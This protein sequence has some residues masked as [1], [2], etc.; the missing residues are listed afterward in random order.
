MR[1]SALAFAVGSVVAIGGCYRARDVERPSE[2]SIVPKTEPVKGSRVADF[3]ADAVYTGDNGTVVGTRWVSTT[4]GM[5]VTVLRI[6]SV[7]QVFLA[8]DTP[9]VS[10]RGEPHTGEHLL[11]GKGTKGKMLSLEQDMSLVD[12]TAWTAQT[13]VCYSWSCAAGKDT[14]Y[15]SVEQ[16]LD[17]LLCPDFSD[18]EIRR[19]VCHIGPVTDEK[20][21][22][23]SVDEKGTIYQEMVSTY[24]KR[25]IVWNEMAKRLWGAGHPLSWSSGGEPAAVRTME[26]RHV[27]EFHAA[28]YQLGPGTRMIVALP[29]SVPEDEFLAK[30]SAQIAA[31]EARPEL[32]A[33]PAAEHPIP[34]GRPAAD[35]SPVV[36]PY[37]NANEDDVGTA[38]IAWAPVPIGAQYDRVAAQILLSTLADGESATLYKRL[39]DSETREVEVGAAE[40]SS[41]LD[42]S[43]IDLLPYVTFDGVPSRN[44]TK[45]RMTQIADVVSSEVRRVAG[46]A[47]DS[48]ALRAFNEKALVKLIEFEKSL[49]RQLDSPP[50]FGHR[51]AGGFWLDQLR[52]VD[53]DPAW[54]RPV[55]LAPSVARLRDEIARGENPWTRIVADFGLGRPPYVGVSAP[56]RAELEKRTADHAK[57]IE[58]YVADLTKRYGGTQE[59]AL[60]KFAADYSAKTAEVDAI[61]KRLGKPKLVADVPLVPDPSIRLEPAD[62]AGVKGF[63]GIFDN[64]TFAEVSVSFRLD[65]VPEDLYPWLAVLPQL[66]TASGVVEDGKP[67]AYDEAEERRAREIH[68]LTAR[69]SM[70]P[71][72]GR[73]ELRVTAS[74]ADASETR[75][76][77]DWIDLSIHHARLDETNLPRLRD[78][79]S[80]A[81]RETRGLLGGAEESWVHDPAEAIRWQRDRLYLCTSSAH[82]RLFQLARCEWKLMDAPSPDEMKEVRAGLDAVASAA[83]DDAAAT[84][85]N[86]DAIVA[87]LKKRDD[88]VAKTWLLPVTLRCREMVGD[89]APTTIAEDLKTLADVAAAD[90]AT[91]PSTALAEV[92]RACDAIFVK[93]GAR[94]VVTGSRKTADSLVPRLASLLG[95][96]A[97]AAPAAAWKTGDPVV[98][99]RAAARSEAGPAPIHYGLVNNA[100]TSGVFLMSAKAGGL[101]D[102]DEKTLVAELASRVFGGGGSHSLFMKTW[103]AGLAYSNGLGVNP[104]E[105]RVHYYAERCPDLVRTMTFATDVVRGAS[106]LDDPYLAEYCVANAVS[107]NRASDEYEQRARAAA[108][109]IADGDTPERIARYRRAVLALKDR[110]GLWASMKPWI[111]PTSGRVLP[112]AGPATHNVAGGLFVTIAPEPLLAR[113]EKYLEDHDDARDR[114]VRVYGR[115]FWIVPR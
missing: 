46:L 81:I 79:V 87:A 22:E 16:Y 57:R 31:I 7:P 90:V 50:L 112:G 72:R 30:L 108:D 100:G 24:E 62:V 28:H 3:I 41:G 48:D 8:F 36:Y 19:E 113:W 11:L 1:R 95:G 93:P 94:F 38:L 43:R 45:E 86:L 15:R 5:P 69:Y 102:L 85:A 65:A 17:A 25:W 9:P 98:D 103:A 71:S 47:P 66:L 26:P 115:D 44:A 14:F 6:Q 52:F 23:I 104:A 84:L 59:Q 35:T 51:N 34:P 83:G 60:A 58:G 20:T 12:S 67:V 39:M 80:A 101:D 73:R 2:E 10:D 110:T 96:L 37:P 40:M 99:A 63:R 53:Q 114:V 49:R 61:E 82:A 78:I 97:D 21:G 106:A 92:R 107:Y 70:R 56:S 88:A 27:R 13:D 111:L 4:T 105:S 74:G 89:M 18:E 109:D 33:R 54:E 91:P 29:D 42:G 77:M 68:A 55:A 64:M 76:A 32:K 75:R